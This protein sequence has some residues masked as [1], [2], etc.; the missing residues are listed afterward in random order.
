MQEIEP[1]PKISCFGKTVMLDNAQD[2]K[3]KE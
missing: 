3:Q 2:T 1:A